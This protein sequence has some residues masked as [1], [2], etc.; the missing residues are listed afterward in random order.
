VRL[1]VMMP[2][3]FPADETPNATY[4][5]KVKRIVGMLWDAGIA[6]VI[7]L[8][9]DV[10]GPVICGEGTPEW[11]WNVSSLNS[12]PFPLPVRL[13]NLSNPDPET[14]GW[15]PKED[16]AIEGPLKSIGWS[17]YYMTDACGKSFQQMYDGVGILGKMVGEYWRTVATALRDT[18]GV[19]AYEILNEPW[20]GDHVSHPALLLK[21]GEAEKASL[22]S[23]MQKMHGIIREADPDTPV[24]FAPAEVN[25][26]LMRRVGYE[27]GFLPGE[28]MAFHT[29]CVTGTDGDG[30]TTFLTK[31]LCHLNDGLQLSQRRSDLKRLRTAGIVTE[32]GAVSDTPTGLAE[33]RFVAD[34]F[35]GNGSPEG[36][37][38]PLSWIY[39]DKIP[40][41][42]DYRRELA[43]SY[44][45]AVA[46]DIVSMKFNAS[47][48]DFLLRFRPHVYSEATNTTGCDPDR[49]TE[50]FLS[51][52]HHY[53]NGWKVDVKPKSCCQVVSGPQGIHIVYNAA[54]SLLERLNTSYVEVKVGRNQG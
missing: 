13:R 15:S 50:V 28:P 30:P 4:I 12:L 44:P 47:S 45:R 40:P 29:Y 9:Q 7:D 52:E 36:E 1:G 14:G 51:R 22:G 31:T 43:R 5:A 46:G 42:E 35:D 34:H 20:L 23:F 27:E 38:T 3:V 6:S 54:S 17:L 49:C 32:F 53:P 37:Q 18:P 39:W 48:G 21:A 2:G 33:V 19:L 41:A 10:L 11:M 25:N 16:C 26:R 24:L 8:H